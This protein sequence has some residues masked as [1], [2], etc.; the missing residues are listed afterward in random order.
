MSL[1]IIDDISGTSY[2]N[3]FGKFIYKVI[4]FFFQMSKDIG[5]DIVLHSIP[6]DVSSIYAIF[7]FNFTVIYFVCKIFCTAVYIHGQRINFLPTISLHT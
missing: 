2:L 5:P 3:V 1:P 4:C 7:Y 6:I